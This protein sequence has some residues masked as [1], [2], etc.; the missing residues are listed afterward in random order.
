MQVAAEVEARGTVLLVEDNRETAEILAEVLRDEG[1]RVVAEVTGVRA[2]AALERMRPQRPDVVL[3]D[4]HLPD[5][6]AD[7]LA[8]RYRDGPGP[9]APLILVT[10]AYRPEQL[11]VEM[12]ADALLAKPFD[13]GALLECVDRY[14][15]VRHGPL[16]RG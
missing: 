13:L 16:V 7:E 9:H 2:L 14:L 1:V 10:A 5:M 11:A 12:G 4:H 3:L 6:D 15:P 8:S